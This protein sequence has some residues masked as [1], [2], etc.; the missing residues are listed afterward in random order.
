M[1]RMSFTKIAEKIGVSPQF[2]SQLANCDKRPNWK[3]AK[4][5][6]AI[7]NTTPELWLDGTKEQIREALST[8]SPSSHRMESASV[9]FE[10]SW[11]AQ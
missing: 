7:T 2:V 3:R 4:Q 1:K 5:L 11:F 6:A 8:K 10:P 9:K